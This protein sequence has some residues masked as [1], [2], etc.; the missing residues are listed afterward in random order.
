MSDPRLT[1]VY[2]EVCWETRGTSAELIKGPNIDAILDLRALTVYMDWS[3]NRNSFTWLKE[4]PKPLYKYRV[5]THDI[6][7]KNLFKAS[8]L[9]RQQLEQDSRLEELCEH[10]KKYENILV[11]RDR[12]H[13]NIIQNLYKLFVIRCEELIGAIR[14]IECDEYREMCRE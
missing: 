12:F 10:L 1:F 3:R 4:L 5:D 11:L 2:T 9:F 6:N 7:E 8:H 14:E 13:D